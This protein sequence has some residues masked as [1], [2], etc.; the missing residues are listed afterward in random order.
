M[1]YA[2]H[3][4][5]TATIAAGARAEQPGPLADAL[6]AIAAGTHLTT[7]AFSERGTRSHFWAQA[8]RARRGRRRRR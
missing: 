5:A 2:M 7:L 8:S 3:V 4:C 1:V 6:R